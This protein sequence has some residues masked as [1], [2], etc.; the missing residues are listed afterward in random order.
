MQKIYFSQQMDWSWFFP[1]FR[2][3]FWTFVNVCIIFSNH[4]FFHFVALFQNTVAL[5][6]WSITPTTQ[7][8]AQSPP[9][10]PLAP[11]RWWVR[12]DYL[13]AQTFLHTYQTHP[14]PALI[15]L[16]SHR[17]MNSAQHVWYFTGGCDEI[18]SGF[19]CPPSRFLYFWDSTGKRWRYSTNVWALNRSVTLR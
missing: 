14:V 3:Y 9:T 7:A 8:S 12:P 1:L 19:S 4:V 15:L 6:Q 17:V 10:W 18:S 13:T 11:E 5:H 2:K 16:V